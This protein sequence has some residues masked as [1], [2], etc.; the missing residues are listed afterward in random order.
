MY[1]KCCVPDCNSTRKDAI[2]HKFPQLT[3]F[4]TLFLQS[5]I[6]SGTPSIPLHDSE[7]ICTRSEKI[8]L[9][10][11]YYASK[12]IYNDHNY[13]TQLQ[14]SQSASENELLEGLP[15]TSKRKLEE[16]S[17][18][19]CQQSISSEPLPSTP[20]RR[21]VEYSEDIYIY[22]HAY[23]KFKIRFKRK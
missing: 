9:D 13:C 22:I 21:L 19:D 7:E 14:T 23:N 12:N 4:P 1:Y 2:L 16:Y 6:L 3:A 15:T 8:D 11:N 10:H 17:I 20:K 18:T 5:E